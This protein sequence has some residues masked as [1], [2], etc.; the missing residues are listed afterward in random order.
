MA[1]LLSALTPVIG[2]DET[3]DSN[4]QYT[5]SV[6]LVDPPESATWS[7][8]LPTLVHGADSKFFARVT[9]TM[10]EMLRETE[11]SDDDDDDNED[12]TTVPHTDD[13]YD[14]ADSFFSSSRSNSTA[15]STPS[16]SGSPSRLPPFSS[17][18]PTSSPFNDTLRLPSS[19]HD[20]HDTPSIHT[21]ASSPDP[22]QIMEIP[23]IPD[24]HNDLLSPVD[25]SNLQLHNFSSLDDTAESWRDSNSTDSGFVDTTKPSLTNVMS[26]PKSP[27]TST[28]GLLHSPFGSPSARVLSPRLGA[29]IGR[30]PSASAQ[31]L[32]TTEKELVPLEDD[33]ESLDSPTHHNAGLASARQLVADSPTPQGARLGP[34]RPASSASSHGDE[35][36]TTQSIYDDLSDQASSSEDDVTGSYGHTDIWDLDAGSTSIYIGQ[37]VQSP[38]APD[39]QQTLSQQSAQSLLLSPV[40]EPAPSWE[41]REAEPSSPASSSTSHPFPVPSF[42]DYKIAGQSSQLVD[43]RDLHDED[44]FDDQTGRWSLE[45]TQD[46]SSLN[47]D[48]TI[49]AI[50]IPEDD[51]AQPLAEAQDRKQVQFATPKSDVQQ[52]P[53]ALEDESWVAGNS[54]Y[55]S[56]DPFAAYPPDENVGQSH[57]EATSAAISISEDNHAQPDRKHVQFATPKDEVQQD[58]SALE[59]DSWLVGNS[60]YSLSADPFAA[61]SPED[62]VTPDEGVAP[63]H[64]D[65]T[66]EAVAILEDNDHA[67]PVPEIQARKHVHFATPKREVQQ[68]P[69][70]VEDESWLVGNA[71]Y[72]VSAD[73]FAAYSPEDDVTPSRPQSSQ[74]QR[75][76]VRFEAP[77]VP[78][79]SEYS[80][81]DDP[82]AADPDDIDARASAAYDE[83]RSPTPSPAFQPDLSSIAEASWVSSSGDGDDTG[84]LGRLA[85][86]TVISN[87]NATAASVDYLEDNLSP[88]S[89]NDKE[90]TEDY[91]DVYYQDEDET[92]LQSND[93]SATLH[94]V[95]RDTAPSDPPVSTAVVDHLEEDRSPKSDNDEELDTEDYSELY[96]RADPGVQW[97]DEVVPVDSVGDSSR[98]DGNAAG[99]SD[100][101]FSEDLSLAQILGRLPMT[102]A[103]TTRLP[104]WDFAAQDTVVSNANA[105]AASVDYLQE[106]LSPSSPNDKELETGDYSDVYLQPDPRF[107]SNDEDDSTALLGYLQ[108]SPEPPEP[109][110]QDGDTINSLYDVYTAEAAPSPQPLPPLSDP[111]TPSSCLRERVFTPPPERLPRYGTPPVQSPAVPSS[112][113]TSLG[114]GS[115]SR[116]GQ[117]PSSEHY[118]SIHDRPP[119]QQSNSHSSVVSK[120]IPFG[121]RASRPSSRSSM[122]S[123]KN[124]SVS[125]LSQL[126]TASLN[127]PGEQEQQA[128][129]TPPPSASSS[130]GPALRPLRLSVLLQS[131]SASH[132]RSYSSTAPSSITSFSV[133]SSSHSNVQDSA[134]AVPVS[135][136][137]SLLNNTSLST[138][139]SA[140]YHTT[141][142]SI[143]DTA[144]SPSLLTE[145]LNH[146][147]TFGSPVSAPVNAPSNWPSHHPASQ[148]YDYRSSS[149]LSEP[150]YEL[151][152]EEDLDDTERQDVRNEPIRRPIL[153][154]PTPRSAS[155]SRPESILHPS[156]HAVAT[157]KPTLMFAIASD[158]VDQVRQVLE[159]GDANPNDLVGPQSALEFALS[160]DQ[161]AN[162]LN[163]VKTLLAFGADPSTLKEDVVEK[164]PS[165]AK[166]GEDQSNEAPSHQAAKT[167]MEGMDP[168]TRYYVERAK[169]P[170]TKRTSRLI[171]RSFFRPLTRVQYDLI[172]QD[173]ALEE[174]FKLLSIHSRQIT[175]SPLVVMFSGPS[176]HGKSLLARKFGSLLDVPTHTVNMVTLRTQ[177]DL[178]ESYSISPV[179]EPTNCTL[180]EFLVNNEGKRCVVVL[181]EIEKVA[182]D[183]V[184]WSLLMPWEHGRCSLE[185]RSRHIDVRNVIWLCTSNI[186][187]DLIFDHWNAREYAEEVLTRQEFLDLVALL[188]PQVSERLGASVLSRITSVLPFVPFTL[189]EKRAMSAEAIF[190]LG[191]ED[192][193]ALTPDEIESLISI[194]LSQYIPEEGARSLHRAVSNHLIDMI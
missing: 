159:N 69:S 26:P 97:N 60:G 49:E 160:N 54:G 80:I 127:G 157:P 28:F 185:A 181:D 78:Y 81:P 133:N 64:T 99:A 83:A 79:N 1:R 152:Q 110:S 156:L 130:T 86:D 93:E 161:L 58:P 168:A 158:D 187:Q 14:F 12:Y 29:F 68:G 98:S 30:S 105:T 92:Q 19:L 184:L 38:Y 55:S 111:S 8:G 11:G 40:R 71:E 137:N 22:V 116:G 188:R 173:R 144:R 45:Y 20:T 192:A 62:D 18:S 148:H 149:R 193:L 56:A 24:N 46:F 176:G 125:Q 77:W 182:N 57:A 178:W 169:A 95:A 121:F 186:G 164:A 73:P 5:D 88:T 117:S 61:Y 72:S 3:E 112:P 122:L 113:P 170:Q 100:D 191:G 155:V 65:A 177:D 189:E 104:P 2:E 134:L 7:S 141:T 146:L 142:N 15:H 109:E 50:D 124:R 89:N 175:V 150:I 114:L 171:H 120:K 183:K 67:Q 47:A 66:I 172:G 162:K 85:H 119:S 180:A 96:R 6:T 63:S 126:S 35:L 167:L 84:V 16:D 33:L 101:Y 107:Q 74:S 108:P 76:V 90:V 25:L 10:A 42:N 140:P 91:T 106:D 4:E 165:G 52:G 82:F 138:P 23:A 9:E 151:E 179:E 131:H 154:T 153:P 34:S 59:D 115:F 174:L 135:S 32:P 128:S 139:R 44:N 48:A 43:D 17:Y 129:S 102:P 132:S 36:V 194:S 123:N 147:A 31:E 37:Q 39:V 75:C 118:Q 70:A 21:T 143:I 41:E 163:I 94:P 53:S 103:T 136:R 13:P 51:H 145:D 166:A 87:A 27:V 190:Q